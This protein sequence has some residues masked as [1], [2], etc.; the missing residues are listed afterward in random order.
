MTRLALLGLRRRAFRLSL[1]AVCIV[2]GAAADSVTAEVGGGESKPTPSIQASFSEYQKLAGRY[3][4]SETLHL[5]G[6]L[7]LTH[8][9]LGA[10]TPGTTLRTGSDWILLAVMDVSADLSKHWSA[11]LQGTGLPPSP[12]DIASP[13]TYPAGRASQQSTAIIKTTS[14]NIGGTVDV[15]YDTF[16]EDGPARAVDGSFGLSLGYAHFATA[17]K[18]TAFDAPGGAVTTESFVKSCGATQTLLCDT[19][20][21]SVGTSTATLEQLRVGATLVGTIYDRT[22]LT[23]DAGYYAYSASDPDA[24]GFFT[25]APA[26]GATA[27]TYGSGLPLLP[28]RYSIRPELGHTWTKFSL[29]AWYQFTD[30]TAADSIGHAVGGKAQLIAGSWRIYTTGSYRADLLSGTAAHTWTLGLGVTRAF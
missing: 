3:D 17:Q 16:D 13:F 9:F 28:P 26:R 23:L 11:G 21:N 29:R 5:S 8:D 18:M 14:A 4:A 2:R 7:R 27:A 19:V 15:Q 12:R 20:S 1:A 22:D 6:S 10:R 24:V 25:F 30:Y